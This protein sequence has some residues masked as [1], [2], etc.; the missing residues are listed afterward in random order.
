[1]Q[2]ADIFAE[3]APAMEDIFGAGCGTVVVALASTC[4]RLATLQSSFLQNLMEAF[5]CW[6]PESRQVKIVHLV[7]R[8]VTFE[9]A[10]TGGQDGQPEFPI[11][12][13]G[14]QIVQTLLHFNKPIKLVQSLLETETAQLKD[15]ACDP[16]GSFIIDAFVASEHVGEKSREKLIHKLQGVYFSLATS[17]HGSRSL[18][19]L[20]Q[21]SDI[22]GRLV[23]GE[24]LLQK[25]AALTSNMFGRIL[26]D[27]Y[28]LPLLKKNKADW[29]TS[30]EKDNKKRKLFAELIDAPALDQ[31]VS[32]KKTKRSKKK[33]TSPENETLEAG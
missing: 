32:T 12:Y 8:L 20:W 23:I 13:M 25:E 7:S 33:K 31:E 1:L 17:K 4:R 15:M 19:A 6:Q 11:H 21:S 2:F 24:E 29:K 5:H 3:L 30:Q 18:D 28:A 27:K 9:V 26:S 16:C 22:K 14:S 10:A